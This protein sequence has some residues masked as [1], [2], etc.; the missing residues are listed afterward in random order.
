MGS[1]LDRDEKLVREMRSGKGRLSP[2]GQLNADEWAKKEPHITSDALRQGLGW[3]RDHGPD[4]LAEPLKRAQQRDAEGHSGL[5]FADDMLRQVTPGS[6]WEIPLAAVGVGK[7]PAKVIGAG[8]AGVLGAN[9]AQAGPADKLAKIMREGA[10]AAK[11]AVREGVAGAK[12]SFRDIVPD[13]AEAKQLEE[14]VASQMPDKHVAGYTGNDTV[15][16]VP[17]GQKPR[18]ELPVTQGAPLPDLQPLNVTP[19]ADQAADPMKGFGE[20]AKREANRARQL[21]AQ[22]ASTAAVEKQSGGGTRAA[23]DP[24]VFRKM[25][26]QQGLDAVLAA[27]QDEQHLKPQAG[28]GWAGA[29]RTVITRR[30]LGDMRQQ[31]DDQVDTAVSGLSHADPDRLGTWYPRARNA[32]MEIH[33]PHQLDRGLEQTAAY[34]AGVAPVAELAF[35]LKH[36]NSRVLGE[37]KRAYRG[38][39][40]ENL[41]TAVASGTP[42]ELAF[43]VGEYR[44]KNDFRVPLDSPFGVNDFRM[45]QS[46]GYTDPKGNPWKAGVTDTMHPF[47]DAETALATQRANQRYGTHQFTGSTLQELPWVQGKAED[48]YSRGNSPTGRYGGEDGRELALRDAN[49]TIADYVPKH[50][51]VGT[52]EALPGKSTG[53]VPEILDAPWEDRL[54]YSQEGDWASEGPLAQSGYHGLEDGPF[55]G[56]P[57]GAIPGGAVGQG[58][59]D[60]IY[61]A[62]NVKTLPTREGAGQFTNSAGEIEN[63]PLGMARMLAD[64]RTVPTA[65][66]HKE[67]IDAGVAIEPVASGTINPDTLQALKFAERFRG[68]NDAQEAFGGNLPV[69]GTSR[70]GR[71]NMLLQRDTLPTADELAK[72]TAQLRGTGFSPVPT[73]RGVLLM[74]EG[75]K[76]GKL[77]KMDFEG[78]YPGGVPE[79]AAMEGVYGPAIGKWGVNAE[80]KEAIVPT[81]PG[82]GEATAGLLEEGAR[83][84]PEAVR[85]IGESDEVRS[86]IGEKRTRDAGYES[87]RPDIDKTRE[88]LQ[89]ADWPRVVALMRK[90]MPAAAAMGALGYSLEGMA[91]EQPQPAR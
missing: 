36:H 86:K 64:F 71:D 6:A 12:A 30:Q 61:R 28:G 41:D 88:F 63:Q 38:A 10:A 57:Y 1:I 79:Q 56:S 84:P 19:S 27:A 50:T 68:V 54:K 31:L 47:M 87:A 55:G 60:S 46:Y 33:E 25:Y 75:G 49:N 21:K 42:A 70:S 59:R 67:A 90:G 32:Q 62:M 51:F 89:T 5:R 20:K 7:V 45:A 65:E 34:S 24:D 82:S 9:E 17:P 26:D 81:V 74:N 23:V 72:L 8:L 40:A 80:G 58:K 48:F 43:K 18:N 4:F 69:T 76:V 15:A 77:R 29:P 3:V 52:Y 85:N 14:Y 39:A 37:P 78:A 13:P 91:A 11:G 73:E 83:T 44:G 66:A 35:A 2:E 16:L 22:Q 53:H